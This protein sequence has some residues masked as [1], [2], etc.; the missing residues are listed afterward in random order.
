MALL[1][2]YSESA[3]ILVVL[4]G[5]LKSILSRGVCLSST[6]REAFV[7]PSRVLRIGVLPGPVNLF[8]CPYARK[9][10]LYPMFRWNSRF[11]AHAAHLKEKS[12]WYMVPVTYPDGNLSLP[13]LE[14]FSIQPQ[15]PVLTAGFSRPSAPPSLTFI[16]GK[17]GSMVGGPL[18]W[19]NSSDKARKE[20]VGPVVV[21][22]VLSDVIEDPS[23][24]PMGIVFKQGSGRRSSRAE[25]PDSPRSKMVRI[26]K[27]RFVPAGNVGWRLFPSRVRNEQDKLKD[28]DDEYTLTADGEISPSRD[29][30]LP[31]PISEADRQNAWW[32]EDNP[33]GVETLSQAV[34][35]AD[36]QGDS[37]P[38]TPTSPAAEFTALPNYEL[39]AARIRRMKERGLQWV[40][41]KSSEPGAAHAASSS[42]QPPISRP[43]P[44]RRRCEV[45]SSVGEREPGSRAGV[46]RLLDA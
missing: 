42:R 40:N 23:Q 17:L 1:L 21:L 6:V 4:A 43:M 8:N 11:R 7:L 22:V 2:W 36:P 33:P 13:F 18:F 31:P 37:R 26:G 27:Y 39:V 20:W 25:R 30:F 38:P 44:L 35:E 16:K 32:L 34:V 3:A 19:A 15:E 10:H 45:Y 46:S 5:A 29:N 14:Y 28:P 24:I 12:G 9:G 41:K